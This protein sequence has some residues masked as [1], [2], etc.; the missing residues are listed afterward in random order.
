MQSTLAT[1]TLGKNLENLT[2]LGS[3]VTG[4]GNELKNFI[5]G[6]DIANSLDGGLGADTMAGNKGND[7]YTVDDIGD[8]VT[9]LTGNGTD[10]IKASVSIAALA[11]FVENLTLTG[12]EDLNGAGN[13]LANLITGNSGEN[14]IFGG[15]LND[16]LT[17][18]AG[19]DTLQG[20][21]GIEL[22]GRRRRQ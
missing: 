21:A 10:E 2:L 7:L 17:G 3:A 8:I 5:T 14:K 15:D 20:D 19:N 9:E 11:N 4:N 16:T 12:I 18:N 13:T 1:T 22:D 6:N